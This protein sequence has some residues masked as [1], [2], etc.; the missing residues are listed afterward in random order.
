M[1]QDKIVEA[2]ESALNYN[3]LVT[4]RDV[5]VWLRGAT[6]LITADAEIAKALGKYR[7]VKRVCKGLWRKK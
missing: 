1:N 6:E 2:S 3:D 4:V 5:R 7:G